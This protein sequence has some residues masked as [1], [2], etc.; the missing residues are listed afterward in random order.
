MDAMPSP[1]PSLSDRMVGS[2]QKKI[3]NWKGPL[4]SCFHVSHGK[5]KKKWVDGEFLSLAGV[6]M[7]RARRQGRD[8][9]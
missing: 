2:L 8:G 7:S 3:A 9:A 1:R 5:K 4:A 6:E